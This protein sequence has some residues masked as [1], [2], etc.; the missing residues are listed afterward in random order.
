[1]SKNKERKDERKYSRPVRRLLRYWNIP[2][3][4]G[5]WGDC[6]RL[7]HHDLS[8]L[9]VGRVASRAQLL[10]DMGLTRTLLDDLLERAAGIG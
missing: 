10:A 8:G 6:A 2:L 4:L 9:V 5:F 7:V 1:M 3:L